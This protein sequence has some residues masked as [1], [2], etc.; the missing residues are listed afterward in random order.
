MQRC[1]CSSDNIKRTTKVRE[2]GQNSFLAQMD[3]VV[4]YN[5]DRSMEKK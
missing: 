3:H 5:G 2:P 4:M 1:G